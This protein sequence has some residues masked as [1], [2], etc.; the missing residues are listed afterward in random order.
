MCNIQHLSVRKGAGR[1]KERER[2]MRKYQIDRD[3][4]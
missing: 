2:A 4:F 3:P 1:V